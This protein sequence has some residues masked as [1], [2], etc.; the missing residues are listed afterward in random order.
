MRTTLLGTAD[1]GTVSI[2]GTDQGEV[3]A[4][5]HDLDVGPTL[6]PEDQAIP[7][8]GHSFRYIKEV[9]PLPSLLQGD[10]APLDY[11][12]VTPISVDLRAWGGFFHVK[13]PIGRMFDR[14]LWVEVVIGW[15]EAS[16]RW[17]VQDPQR[18]REKWLTAEELYAYQGRSAL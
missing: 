7:V 16:K 18:T 17:I 9:P 14:Y 10:P 4:W 11:I 5:K 13:N 12:S 1:Y 8:R 6:P 15:D 2:F 3:F